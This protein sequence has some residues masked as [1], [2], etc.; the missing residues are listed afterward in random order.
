MLEQIVMLEGRRRIHQSL[1][2]GWN[3]SDDILIERSHRFLS[4]QHL[5]RPYQQAFEIDVNQR[6]LN[7]FYNNSLPLLL[8]YNPNSFPFD[9]KSLNQCLVVRYNL[10]YTLMDLLIEILYNSSNNKDLDWM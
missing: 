7:K 4:Y 5:D 2:I 3:L 8:W 1:S 10:Y 6:D 9:R